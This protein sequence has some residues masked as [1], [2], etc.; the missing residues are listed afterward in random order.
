MRISDWSSDVCSSDLVDGATANI[1]IA[2][3]L[4]LGTP[5]FILFGWLSDR[6]GRKPIILAGCAL[7]AITYFPAFQMLTAAANPA[8]AAA[9]AHAEVTV[10]ADPGRSSFQFE[11][12]AQNKC[13]RTGCDN[14]KAAPAK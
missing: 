6:I 5:F 3:A 2:L 1:M 4:A 12:V 13:A 14:S 9:Q 7:A 11:P 10:T 8:L